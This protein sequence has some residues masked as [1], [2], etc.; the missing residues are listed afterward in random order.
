MGFIA[1][2]T[3]FLSIIVLT[4][5]SF[6]FS[7]F[8]VSPSRP[9][10]PARPTI[11]HTIASYFRAQPSP[12]TSALPGS[13]ASP[14]PSGTHDWWHPNSRVTALTAAR[15]QLPPL[16]LCRTI[17]YSTHRASRRA[18]PQ[19]EPR[20]LPVAAAVWATAMTT[21]IIITIRPLSVRPERLTTTTPAIRPAR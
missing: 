11:N 5:V 18:V 20:P 13:A 19:V 4:M 8:C 7:P 2:V 16:R 14:G 1:C 17:R 6:F 15:P 21:S 9:V 3:I 10:S 12:T